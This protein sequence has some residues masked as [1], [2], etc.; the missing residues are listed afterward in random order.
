MH[1]LITGLHIYTSPDF[2]KGPSSELS[3][4]PSSEPSASPSFRSTSS[5][6]P[7]GFRYIEGDSGGSAPGALCGLYPREFLLVLGLYGLD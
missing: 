4:S 7:D 6:S 1:L 3:P 5:P 2:V